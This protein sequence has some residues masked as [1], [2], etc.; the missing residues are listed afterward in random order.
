MVKHTCATMY[1]SAAA[2]YTFLPGDACESTDSA[3]FSVRRYHDASKHSASRHD[4]QLRV[5]STV[6]A[7]ATAPADRSSNNY[8]HRGHWPR[9]SSRR[10]RAVADDTDRQQSQLYPHQPALQT[11]ISTQTF[12]L[13]PARVAA[14]TLGATLALS[15]TVQSASTRDAA[16]N[17]RRSYD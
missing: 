5:G 6:T 15:R 16:W 14:L 10:R 12:Q 13:A 4:Y 17:Y 8:K 9:H 11:L 7:S 2:A 1:H 3:T